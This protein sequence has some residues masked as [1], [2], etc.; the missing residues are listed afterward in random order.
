MPTWKGLEGPGGDGYVPDDLEAVS[1]GEGQ[2]AHAEPLGGTDAGEGRGDGVDGVRASVRQ[3]E[4][5]GGISQDGGA[6]AV[7]KRR[8]KGNNTCS[9]GP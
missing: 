2:R 9:G 5:V 4:G 1:P 3:E 7:G 8:R 6:G